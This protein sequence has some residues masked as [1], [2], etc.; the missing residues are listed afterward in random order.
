MCL[1]GSGRAVDCGTRY[2]M[3]AITTTATGGEG[4][5]MG[6]HQLCVGVRVGR[7]RGRV[8]VVYNVSVERGRGRERDRERERGRGKEGGREEGERERE[9]YCE[10]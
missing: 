2:G 3:V 1:T 10:L 7:D 5:A 8:L 6:I 4:G 9:V